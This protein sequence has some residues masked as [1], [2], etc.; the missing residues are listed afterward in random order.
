[1]SQC[2]VLQVNCADKSFTLNDKVFKRTE[3][4]YF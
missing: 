2:E 3:T 1:M 4:F